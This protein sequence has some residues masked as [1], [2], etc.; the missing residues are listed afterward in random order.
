MGSYSRSDGVSAAGAATQGAAKASTRTRTGASMVLDRYLTRETGK[1]FCLIALFLT[2]LF[3]AFS[4]TRFLTEANEGLLTASAVFNLTLLKALIAL[5]VLLPIALYI[6]LIVALG[7]LYSDWE[8]IALRA[9]GVSENRVLAPVLGMAAAVAVAVA[10]L[11]LWARPWAYDLLYRLEAEAAAEVELDALS[12]GRFHLYGGAERTVFLDAREGDGELK[13][14]FVRSEREGALEVISAGRG[15]LDAFARPDAHLLELFNAFIYRQPSTPEESAVS[16]R[17]AAG[18]SPD[19]N[20]GADDAKARLGRTG[21]APCAASAAESRNLVGRF[22]SLSIWTAAMAPEP[23]RHRPK[24]AGTRELWS[25]PHSEDRAEAQWRAS[26]AFSTLLLALMAVPLSR[27]RPRGGR[28]ARVLLAVVIY[29]LYFNF[30]GIARTEV[31]RGALP[32]LWWAP[33]GLAACLGAAWLASR[34]T[35]P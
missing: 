2:G 17:Q 11:S 29:A 27:V 13:G 4:L 24:A 19:A 25:S 22:D 15:R 34:R 1:P 26:T 30:I 10:A 18:A 20:D 33:G 32:Y 31:E 23:L 9:G 12:P 7:R 21:S 8:I 14:V 28:Y 16:C 5:E 3:I 35:A 6:G